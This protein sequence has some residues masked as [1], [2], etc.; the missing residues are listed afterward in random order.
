MFVRPVAASMALSGRIV[1]D[2]L[3]T[4][5]PALLAAA[6]A[7]VA[8]VAGSFAAAGPTPE[9]VVAGVSALVVDRSPAALTTAAISLLRDYAIVLAGATALGLTLALFG[10]VAYA[11]IRLGRRSS[12]PLTAAVLGAAGA[13]ALATLLTGA[14]ALSLAT[15]L[16]VGAAL[17]LAEL[18][19]RVGGRRPASLSRRGALKSLGAAAVAVAGAYLLGRGKTGAPGGEG[20]TAPLSVIAD[21]STAAEARRRVEAARERSLD[22]P[23]LEGLVTEIGSFYEVDIN[24]TNPDPTAEYWNLTVKGAVGRELSVG[25]DDLLGMGL[26]HRFNTLRCVSD[27]LNGEKMD[28]ALWTGV[29]IA[30]V[31]EEANV[32]ENCCVMLRAVDDYFQ[33]FPLEALREGFLAVGMNGRV[34]PRGHG[35]PVRALIP[36]HWGEIQ[37]KWLTEI[38]VLR[39]PAEGYWEQRGWHGTGPVNTVAK[40]HALN[41]LD[42]DR[43]QVGGH[44]YAGTRGVDR[45]EVSTDGGEQWVEA[46]VTEPLPD[47][48]S[49]RQWEHVY[50][51][52]DPHEVVV[53]AV[54]GEGDVQPEEYQEPYP[55]GATGW[56]SREIEP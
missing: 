46:T 48:D 17:A 39:E 23:G 14:A 27:P 13:W 47:G 43:I 41:R 11:A 35:H 31:I 18:R 40:L 29:P 25:Y 7:A 5:A 8:G 26:E 2:R 44:A 49:W 30:T 56:V 32:P 16:P 3:R 37:V 4:D 20:E 19:L 53:R 55:R 10:A 51:A 33:E 1:P 42:G 9:F 36:G 54:D 22:V 15:G 50:R 28:N 24:V 38:E 52:S 12:V 45:V 21:E 34:L 6:V